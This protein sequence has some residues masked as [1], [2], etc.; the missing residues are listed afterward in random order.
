MKRILITLAAACITL[1]AFAQNFPAGMRSELVEIE[2]DEN[3]YS[4]FSYKDNDGTTGYY[5]SL[6]T[7]IPI[8]EV[9]GDNSSS[10]LSHIDE[11]C[12]YMGETEEDALA[13]L[14]SLLELV[15]QEAGAVA[16]FPCRMTFGAES[17]GESSTATCMVVSRFLQTKRLSF[18]FSSGGH[19]AQ[20]DLTKSAIRSLR[21][22]VVTYQRLHPKR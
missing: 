12:L 3:E 22:G 18:I 2:Q 15:D 20:A 19:T 1:C 8:L 21:A 14:D 5:M 4:V 9:I 7:V 17:L 10:S 16:K 11:T 13:F 6:G